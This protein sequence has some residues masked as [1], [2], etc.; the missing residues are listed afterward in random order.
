MTFEHGLCTWKELFHFDSERKFSS[1]ICFQSNITIQFSTTLLKIV[2]AFICQSAGKL[3]TNFIDL[4][5]ISRNH[6]SCNPAEPPWCRQNTNQSLNSQK[7]SHMIPFL[8][9]VGPRWAPCWP[10]ELCYLGRIWGHRDSHYNAKMVSWPSYH[11]SFLCN[12]N[13]VL[14]VGLMWGVHE[15]GVQSH[16]VALNSTSE[17]NVRIES[18]TLPVIDVSHW[19][20]TFSSIKSWCCVHVAC[21]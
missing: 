4:C 2:L 11:A 14:T 3:V 13:Y 16:I 18:L 19:S 9:P 5:Q 6:A 15:V 21:W 20:T 7:T 8:Y 17:D 1:L 10:H 12:I